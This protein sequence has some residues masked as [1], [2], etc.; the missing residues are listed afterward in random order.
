MSG[1]GETVGPYIFNITILRV[2]VTLQVHP[3]LIQSDSDRVSLT[4]DIVSL[5]YTGLKPV[6]NEE[7]QFT[8]LKGFS[9]A[10]ISYR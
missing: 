4:G 5:R 2:K 7:I 1:C 3:I 6:D 10:V 9:T 8:I